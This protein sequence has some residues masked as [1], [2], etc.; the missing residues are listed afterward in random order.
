LN[1][2]QDLPNLLEKCL[3]LADKST[4]LLVGHCPVR[5]PGRGDNTGD[6]PNDSS[7][8][9]SPAV[10]TTILTYRSPRRSSCRFFPLCRPRRLPKSPIN[11][12]REA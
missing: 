2:P 10:T 5:R 9:V 7:V 1:T 12:R 4:R 3:G 11:Q 8:I 6:I